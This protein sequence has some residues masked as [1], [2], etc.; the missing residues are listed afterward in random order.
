MLADPERHLSKRHC[1]IAGRDGVLGDHRPQHQRHV[2]E[3]RREP[4]GR[5]NVRDLR[6]GDRLRL[7]GYEIEL[8][9]AETPRDRIARLI[10]PAT[11]R[12][13]AVSRTTRPGSRMRSAHRR[14]VVLLDDDWDLDGPLPLPVRPRRPRRSRQRRPG[15]SR[16]TSR[17]RGTAGGVSAR[18]RPAGRAVADPPRMEELGGVFRALVSGLRE[19][20]VARAAVK[21]EFR[22]AQTLIRARGNNPLK[23]SASDEDAMLALLGAGRRSDIGRRRCGA[24]SAARHPPARTGNDGRDADRGAR[25]VA[26]T[27]AGETAR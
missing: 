1:V 27:R 11:V 10:A 19:T 24:G 2:P 9:I 18:R 15:I 5:G 14:P 13:S 22:I 17:N 25:A 20:L 23:F 6:D 12:R 7:G 21:N 26:G 3:R 8:R 16:R 4:I